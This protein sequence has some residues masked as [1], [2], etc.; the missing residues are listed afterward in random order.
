[1]KRINKTKWWV[2]IGIVAVIVIALIAVFSVQ[3]PK[4]EVI[5]I[6]VMTPLTGF[7]QEN[8]Q[9]I[10][11]GIELAYS[12]I[13]FK[14]SKVELIFEDSMCDPKTGISAYH[15]LRNKGCNI[16]IG[17]VCSGVTLAVAPLAEQ[18]KVVF[19]SATASS[20]EIT[21]AGDYIF[22]VYPSD[23]LDALTLSNFV[24]G[25]NV[26]VVS[27]NND[28]GEGIVEKLEEKLEKKIILKEKFK[29]GESD[30]RSILTKIKSSNSQAIILVGYP[31]NTLNFLQQAKELG[32]NKTIVG[33]TATFTVNLFDKDYPNFYFTSPNIPSKERNF[34]IE[35]YKMKYGVEP[36]FPAEYGYDNFLILATALNKTKNVKNLKEELY[37]TSAFGATGK[38][39]FDSNG[40]RTGMEMGVYQIRNHKIECV[41]NCEYE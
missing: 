18:D 34:F 4:E 26:S 12:Q 33:S 14:N 32:I 19:I 2:M 31:E 38:I 25:K 7:S 15:S 11:K 39:G 23:E 5:K 3:K 1:M 8:G 40:D 27:I 30:F 29:I 35:L 22:R 37:K 41:F 9:Y 21:N 28:Y 10:R 6:G 16:M 13:K 24:K 20:P 36:N 17:S